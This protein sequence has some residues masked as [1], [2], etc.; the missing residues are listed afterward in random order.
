MMFDLAVHVET[1]LG[2]Q[3]NYYRSNPFPHV[4]FDI[5]LR[6]N[7]PCA[8]Y[9]RGTA[10]QQQSC[11]STG[12]VSATLESLAVGMCFAVSQ[13]PVV[14]VG[15]TCSAVSG[16]FLPYLGHPAAAIPVIID[17][18]SFP[19]CNSSIA[20]HPGAPVATGGVQGYACADGTILPG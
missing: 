4:N 3:G 1:T 20:L 2:T 5:E 19:I 14:L 12:V 15:G 9:L 17:E 18:S 7:N 13:E 10:A 8:T 6:L 11:L 16:I